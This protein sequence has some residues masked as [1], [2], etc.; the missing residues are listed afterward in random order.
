MVSHA[1]CSLPPRKANEV[2]LVIKEVL[3]GAILPAGYRHQMAVWQTAASKVAPVRLEPAEGPPREDLQLEIENN[4]PHG[5]HVFLPS[6]EEPSSQEVAL[7][8]H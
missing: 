4:A 2:A 8:R 5:L 6:A 1:T 7:E 3:P